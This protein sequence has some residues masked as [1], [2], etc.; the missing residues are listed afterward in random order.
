M[1]APPENRPHRQ[2]K[3]DGGT[4]EPQGDLGER[5]LQPPASQVIDLLEPN[6]GVMKQSAI[7]AETGWSAAKV[8]RT[9]TKLEREGSIRKVS[10]GRENLIVQEGKEPDWFTRAL[11][12]E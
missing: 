12:D 10:L 2:A 8:S 7:V 6:D 9:L 5:T 11:V 4:L 3:A 1:G